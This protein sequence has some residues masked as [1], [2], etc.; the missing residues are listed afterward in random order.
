MNRNISVQNENDIATTDEEIACDNQHKDIDDNTHDNDTKYKNDDNYE[1]DN[2][3]DDNY[4]Y[5]PK[6]LPCGHVFHVTCIARWCVES[7]TCPVCRAYC[8]GI[9]GFDGAGN[10]TGVEG[11][12]PLHIDD[13]DDSYGHIHSISG[14]RA[15]SYRGVNG[16]DD[17]YAT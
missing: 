3:V 12:L 15:R 9:E 6:M 16:E 2:D 11:Q 7:G 8:G 17:E 13:D 14:G 4:A 1:S 10:G 5:L